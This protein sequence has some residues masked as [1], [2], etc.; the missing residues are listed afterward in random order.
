LGYEALTDRKDVLDIWGEKFPKEIFSGNE[1][2]YLEK[3]SGSQVPSVKFIWAEMDRTWDQLQLDNHK[4]LALQDI[5][6][7][8]G[9]PVW[10]LNAIFT[11]ADG[12]SRAHRTSIASFIHSTGARRIAD[13]GGGGAELAKQ[14]ELQCPG[15][16][17]DIV[18]PYPSSLGKFRV[19][20]LKNT[21]FI[22]TLGDGYDLIVA[23]DV[24]EHVE[25]P[26]L[27]AQSIYQALK[28]GGI[29][30]FANCFFPVIKCHL[31]GTFH[32]RATF[33]MIVAAGGL[34]FVQVVEGAEHAQVFVKAGVLP[35][36]PPRVFLLEKVSIVLW[37]F[38][39]A[40][41]GLSKLLRPKKITG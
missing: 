37:P 39:R 35:E 15:A 30:I 17:I 5:A 12:E 31:P 9:H 25:H 14:V 29:A 36:F 19:S 3:Y 8:Y 23:Q 10:I 41:V 2:E 6:T 4:S 21:K 32:L 16:V 7:F 27:V 24:L 18:E 1:L 34:K 20:K 28:P 40:A 33:A 11:A 13:Y 26:L 22:A 38:I